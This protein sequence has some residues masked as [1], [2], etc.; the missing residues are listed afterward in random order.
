MNMKV[1]KLKKN[2]KVGLEFTRTEVHLLKQIRRDFWPKLDIF[3]TAI[4]LPEIGA[5]IRRAPWRSSEVP[6]AVRRF[7]YEIRCQLAE[8]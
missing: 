7:R 3:K 5:G 8:C 6:E 1:T 2:G 4:K